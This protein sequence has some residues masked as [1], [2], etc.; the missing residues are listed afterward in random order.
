MIL[1]DRFRT[2]IIDMSEQDLV[3]KK[4]ENLSY[5]SK[6]IQ[7]NSKHFKGTLALNSK[8]SKSVSNNLQR[9]KD[10][11]DQSDRSVF[12]PP[13]KKKTSEK[14]NQI[15]QLHEKNVE[16]GEPKDITSRNS[17]NTAA[18]SL[19]TRRLS[20]VSIRARLKNDRSG[21]IIKVYT[22]L[23][24][25]LLITSLFTGVT[26]AY[27][28]LQKGIKKANP[29]VILVSVLLLI[30]IICIL[31]FKK[32]ARKVPY[33]YAALFMFTLFQSYIVAY[34]CAFYNPLIV[35]FAALITL[36]VAVSLMIYACLSKNDF[37]TIGGILVSCTTSLV[38]FLILLIFFSKFY[39]NLIICE[40][41]ILFYSIFIV[42]DT[43]LIAG[44]RYKEIELDDYIIGSLILY[45]DIIGL[46]AYLIAACFDTSS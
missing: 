45:V 33:N 19:E 7:N 27:P 30:L 26:F 5:H 8:S 2:I 34:I 16:N 3:T 21:F 15:L 28:S 42:F 41:F 18:D 17:L 4:A 29:V 35:T 38:I 40:I 22:L 31:S 11:Q 46:F 12:L 1:N 32:L 13:K 20:T 6:S 39:V 10:D 25:Q 9:V 36:S 24:I 23:S 37:T 43:Q 14:V 44:G